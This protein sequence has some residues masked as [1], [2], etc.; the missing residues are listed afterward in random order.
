MMVELNKHFGKVSVKDV[1]LQVKTLEK[2]EQSFVLM[3]ILQ[4]Y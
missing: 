3:Q 2:I 1:N 4:D